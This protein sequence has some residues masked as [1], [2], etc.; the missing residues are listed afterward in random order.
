MTEL[1]RISAAAILLAIAA[2]LLRELGWRGAIAF[3]VFGAAVFLSF[4]AD[5]LKDA[6][7]GITRVA[8]ASG[9]LTL[10]GEILKVLGASYVF[11]IASDI[12]RELGEK[13]TASALLA[14][15]RVE[16]FLISMPYFIKIAEYAVGLVLG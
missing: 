15:G 9:T 2:Y 11:G 6:V 10:A 1:I 7:G 5:G 4:L 12:C 14:V 13:T 3:S 8:E 16:I